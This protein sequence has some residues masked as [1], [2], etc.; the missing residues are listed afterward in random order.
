MDITNKFQNAKI[1]KITDIGYNKC[2]I[3]LT[4]EE[5]SMR[6][7]RHRATF[8]QFL[9]RNYRRVSSF[10]LFNEYGVENYKIELIEYYKCD[11]LQELRKQEGLHIKNTECVNK[12]VAG[13]TISEWVEDNKDKIREQNKEYQ[14]ANKSI[15]Q[16][17]KKEYYV[18]NKDKIL[19][20][21][22]KYREANRDKVNA[23][24]LKY[25]EANKDKIKAKRC[26]QSKQQKAD[27]S[28]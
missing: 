27:T 4:C 15:I 13:R 2:Y 11:T 10:D 24:K 14:K 9:N 28:V 21:Q 20:R 23:Q 25:Y 7:A 1:Y 5:L 12:C 18:D 19:E 16:E 26:E 8:K 17:Q 22:K 6:M 3:G